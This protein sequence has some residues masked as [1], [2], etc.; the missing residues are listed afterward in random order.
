[1]FKLLSRGNAKLYTA[2]DSKSE[3]KTMIRTLNGGNKTSTLEA[4]I[5][6]DT[7]LK[8]ACKTLTASDKVFG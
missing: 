7:L 4:Q 8:Q 5:V 2:A 3:Y 1:M 6:N